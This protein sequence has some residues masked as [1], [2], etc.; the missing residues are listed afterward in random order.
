MPTLYDLALQLGSIKQMGARD[1]AIWAV[2]FLSCAWFGPLLHSFVLL[3][4]VATTTPE[5]APLMWEAPT[6]Y[7][8][9]KG[10]MKMI[11]YG[12]W[13]STQWHILVLIYRAAAGGL[14]MDKFGVW[15]E[16]DTIAA[17]LAPLP[18]LIPGHYYARLKD[19]NPCLLL[20]LISIWHHSS[21]YIYPWL[22]YMLRP[23]TN[24]RLIRLTYVA[25]HLL[26]AFFQG[27]LQGLLLGES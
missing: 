26:L 8:K 24:R 2:E 13:E 1:W 9:L 11:L 16:A 7:G 23:S 21:V 20:A 12:L 14:Q 19:E 3:F 15:P 25:S 18:T 22:S 27:F 6:N 10:G 17:I 4:Y 5:L